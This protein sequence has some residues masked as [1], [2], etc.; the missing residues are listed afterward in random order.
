MQAV[1]R[2]IA[3]VGEIFVY[4]CQRENSTLSWEQNFI[5]CH[6]IYPDNIN[7]GRFPQTAWRCKQLADLMTICKLLRVNLILYN[8]CQ[9]DSKFVNNILMW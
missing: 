9:F 2:I 4:Y 3:F 7:I 6:H 1:C 8:K 5:I